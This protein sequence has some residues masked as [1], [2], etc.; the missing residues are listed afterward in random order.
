MYGILKTT[1]TERERSYVI[2]IH[3]KWKWATRGPLSCQEY[4][5]NV[6]K[7]LLIRWTT[8][9]LPLHPPHTIYDHFIIII[10]LEISSQLN[11]TGRWKLCINYYSLGFTV[12]GVDGVSASHRISISILEGVVSVCVRVCGMWVVCGALHRTVALLYWMKWTRIRCQARLNLNLLPSPWLPNHFNYLLSAP[13]PPPPRLGHPH[14]ELHL[15]YY[16]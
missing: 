1:A 10:W 9:Y 5:S 3:I 13:F 16:V 8:L 14:D 12:D 2:R 15:P 7:E 11:P 6:V 4:H